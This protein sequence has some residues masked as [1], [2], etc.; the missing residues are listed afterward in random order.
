MLAIVS[1]GRML[2]VVLAAIDWSVAAP[3]VIHYAA[4]ART[5]PP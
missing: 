3:T 1:L 5:H 2:L 4:R